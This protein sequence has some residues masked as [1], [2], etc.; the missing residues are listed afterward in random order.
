MTIIPPYLQKGDLIGITC[1]ASYMSR[2]NAEKC[3]ASLQQWGYEVMVGKT[4]GS[5]SKNYFSATDEERTD[6][7]QAMLDDKNIRA[8]IFGRGGYGTGRII[9]RLDFKKFKKHPKWI[10]GFS[11]ITLLHS[12]LFTRLNMASIHGPMA[13]G[14]NKGKSDTA[15]I[16]SLR[17]IIAGKKSAYTCKPTKHNRIGTAKGVLVGGN[18]ALLVNAIGTPSEVDMRGKLLFIEDVGEYLYA[19][20]RMFYQLKRSG[21]LAKLSGLILGGFTDLK[22]TERP[23]G[24]NFREML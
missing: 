11:D 10:I 7:L 12:H 21:K 24:K 18:L 13:I 14:F 3:I 8:I 19:L 20:D 23:F 22:D 4:L 2:E 17:E 5:S 9:D 6:E 1:P 15:S 16:V